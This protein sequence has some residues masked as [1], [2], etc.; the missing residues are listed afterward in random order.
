MLLSDFSLIAE[1]PRL[2]TAFRESHPCGWCYVKC[3]TNKI[4]TGNMA[5]INLA[6]A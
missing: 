2:N 6:A 4:H 5:N 3:K 1:H